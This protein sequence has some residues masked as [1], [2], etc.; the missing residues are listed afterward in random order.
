MTVQQQRVIDLIVEGAIKKGFTF[1]IKAPR[2]DREGARITVRN[3][4]YPF[5]VIGIAPDGWAGVVES[6][7]G[8]DRPLSTF[9]RLILNKAKKLRKAP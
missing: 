7:Q 4:R 2:D 6:S 3:G 1:E 8:Y 9:I 5:D